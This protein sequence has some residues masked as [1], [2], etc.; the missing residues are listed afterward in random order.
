MI[1][2]SLSK[3]G[4]A[5]FFTTLDLGSAFWQVPLRKQDSD[6]TRKVTVGQ[7]LRRLLEKPADDETLVS[8]SG[9][10]GPE[11]TIMRRGEV[12]NGGNSMKAREPENKEVLRSLVEKTP[13]DVL[14]QKT[15]QR[16]RV[17]FKKEVE[18]L[19]QDYQFCEWPT[20]DRDGEKESFYGESEE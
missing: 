7:D 6:K 15:L 9:N 11:V 13:V 19:G 18:D 20:T 12:T 1:D 10:D 3:L 8:K 14:R 4:D 5:N 2:E 17:S 16:K